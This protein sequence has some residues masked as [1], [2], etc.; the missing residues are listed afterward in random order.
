MKQ[1]FDS[2]Y[3]EFVRLFNT[4]EYWHAHEVLE[5]LWLE[6]RENPD[7]IF[8]K[9]MIQ[10]AAVLYHV[11]K[12]NFTGAW[13]LFAS[14]GGY[15]SQYPQEHLGIHSGKLLTSINCFVT[16]R[17]KQGLGSKAERPIICL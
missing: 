16:A 13:S 8:Y 6:Q 5:N 4:R 12:E 15:L 2:R 10:L 11:E 1:N 14:A 3:L 17:E 7:R 9:A